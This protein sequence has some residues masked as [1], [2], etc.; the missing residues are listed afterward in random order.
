[1]RWLVLPSR[2]PDDSPSFWCAEPFPAE[3]DASQP[4]G[5]LQLGMQFSQTASASPGAA[6]HR[7]RLI[8]AQ[9]RSTA[10]SLF[11]IFTGAL[12][13]KKTISFLDYRLPLAQLLS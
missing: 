13:I 12:A 2:D 11:A 9:A 10:W 3:V 5:P 6:T 8:F 4:A 7:Q 1:M